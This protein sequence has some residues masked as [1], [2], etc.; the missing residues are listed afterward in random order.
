MIMNEKLYKEC[1]KISEG[2]K[3]N[4][5]YCQCKVENTL[6]YMLIMKLI[7]SKYSKDLSPQC[8]KQLM[9]LKSKY[10]HE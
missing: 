3:F 8:Y 5:N 1:C 9:I 4:I 2:A 7:N 10:E 6:Y